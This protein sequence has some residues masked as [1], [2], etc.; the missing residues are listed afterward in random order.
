M[1]PKSS[2]P[3]SSS[4]KLSSPKTSSP[5]LS[6]PWSSSPKSLSPKSSS[7]SR[8]SIFEKFGDLSA[9]IAQ[10]LIDDDIA[11]TLMGNKDGEY[12]LNK[13][14]LHYILQQLINENITDT[15]K[16]KKTIQN[17]LDFLILDR[18]NAEYERL[19]YIFK[20]CMKNRKFSFDFESLLY[21]E[22]ETKLVKFFTKTI[23]DKELTGEKRYD[24]IFSDICE[25]IKDEFYDYRDKTDNMVLKVLQYLGKH[26]KF[27]LQQFVKLSLSFLHGF[28]EYAGIEIITVFI[29]TFF[30]QEYIDQ[31]AS[32]ENIKEIHKTMLIVYQEI[33]KRILFAVHKTNDG[34]LELKLRLRNETKEAK[35]LIRNL[36]KRINEIIIKFDSNDFQDRKIQKTLLI[37]I[38]THYIKTEI[39]LGNADT[40]KIL[41]QHN[42]H[43]NVQYVVSDFRIVD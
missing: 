7:Y 16:Y 20:F 41:Q 19:L 32:K 31:A 38:E 42:V 5:K 22:N 37:E 36:I 28:D 33:F 1:P 15:T 34:N 27:N 12:I 10:N 13:K 35:V 17:L 29:K 43:A 30:E 11:K 21:S 40:L 25:Y 23:A 3:K 6:S 14:E 9:N 26:R 39:I 8:R 24:K 4:P 18:N 2:S